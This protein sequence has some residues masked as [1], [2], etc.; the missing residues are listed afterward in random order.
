MNNLRMFLKT[1]KDLNTI[2]MECA[3]VARGLSEESTKALLKG[4]FTDLTGF[5]RNL[6]GQHY[7]FPCPE[8]SPRGNYKPY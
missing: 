7:L 6:Q 8:C 1:K 5:G 2:I 3:R 4:T